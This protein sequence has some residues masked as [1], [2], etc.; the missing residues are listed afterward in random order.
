MSLSKICYISHLPS[1]FSL[2]SLGQ[3]LIERNTPATVSPDHEEQEAKLRICLNWNMVVLSSEN[4]MS[5]QVLTLHLTNG[6]ITRQVWVS[7]KKGVGLNETWLSLKG[8]HQLVPAISK[9]F[10]QMHTV[11]KGYM[12]HVLLRPKLPRRG[13]C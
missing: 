7:L 6:A 11:G 2:A 12:H 4:Y 1:S 8:H 5:S 9:T 13:F 10:F 3:L